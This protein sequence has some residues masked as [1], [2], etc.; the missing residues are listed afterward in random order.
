MPTQNT[1]GGTVNSFDNTPIAKDDKL[2]VNEDDAGSIFYFDVMGNDLSGKAKTLWSLDNGQ[3]NDLLSQDLARTAASTPDTSALGARIWITDDGKV[4]YDAA[5][6][7]SVIQALAAGETIQDTFLY[8]IRVANGTL[9]WAT[10]TVTITGQ[11]DKSVISGDTSGKVV[12]TGYFEEG[13]VKPGTP[14][15]S[16][17]LTITDPDSVTTF[18][19]LNSVPSQS[20][21]GSFSINAAGQW[22]YTLNDANPAVNAL[23]DGDKL[24]DTVTVR[25]TDGTMQT[26][27]MTIFGVND[28]RHASDY[29][30]TGD[31][32][33]FDG[34]V[35]ANP[36]NNA[37][38]IDGTNLA[39]DN[40]TGGAAAQNIDG[41]GGNDSIFGAGGDDTLI[42]NAGNDLLYGQAGND[43]ITG[44]AG[45]DGLYGGS[46]NDT[47]NGGTDSDNMYGGSGADILSGGLGNDVIVGG[48]GA[49]R[50]TGGDGNDSFVMLDLRDTNDIITGFVFGSDSLN[51]SALDADG[52]TDANDTFVWGGGTATAH[53]V[54]TRTDGNNTTIFADTDGNLDTAEFMVTLLNVGYTP[55]AAPPAEF[56]L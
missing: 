14:V 11:D 39:N 55:E 49:D 27:T 16:G 56:I 7:S 51:L 52:S 47:L 10:A 3:S 30:G 54:W 5:G 43:L 23:N 8:A 42:G 36:A 44:N 17:V 4:G 34:L 2:V 31:S 15:A 1:K 12:E 22:A 6:A 9:S 46:G 50:L 45:L 35:G 32:N 33:D 40:I 38:A 13:G 48:F 21:Y 25:T 19:P 26:V 37:A 41:K 28:F 24:T 18:V 20:G 53:G 29:T